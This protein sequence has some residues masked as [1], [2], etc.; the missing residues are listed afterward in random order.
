MH[1]GL[2]KLT[3]NQ[4]PRPPDT[5]RPWKNYVK[6]TFPSSDDLQVLQNL[7]EINVVVLLMHSGLE[8][9]TWNQRFRPPEAFRS[10]K[11][12]VKSTSSSSWCIQALKEIT[13]NQRFRPPKAFRSCKIYVKSTSSWCIQALKKLREINVSALL[14]TPEALRSCKIYVKLTSS[15][16]WWSG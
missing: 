9:N 7:R 10:C 5:S 2:E 8:K 12:Y 11:I 1:P 15:S 6:S 13:W 16:S 4:R 14:P 3:W